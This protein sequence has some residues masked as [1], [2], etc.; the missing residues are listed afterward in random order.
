MSLST[1]H[2]DTSERDTESTSHVAD[3]DVSETEKN[4]QING[5]ILEGNKG[6]VEEEDIFIVP[7]HVA[8]KTVGFSL[9]G[10]K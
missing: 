7:A 5:N 1:E 8:T 3:R 10:G 2:K 4:V 6:D 9:D